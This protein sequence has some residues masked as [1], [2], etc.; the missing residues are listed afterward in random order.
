M[1]F[2]YILQSLKNKA[3]Y[4][5]SC[6]DVTI[7]LIQHNNG[8]VKSTKRYSPWRLVYKENYVN[9]SLA[10]TRELQIK[11]WKKRSSIEN[12]IKTF[13]NF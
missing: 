1:F 9:L 8:T 2:V 6:G 12:L 7:R 5:G 4:V 3:Y 11:S 10:R 13:Q